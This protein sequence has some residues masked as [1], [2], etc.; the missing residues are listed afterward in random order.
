VGSGIA[1]NFCHPNSM[2]PGRCRPGGRGDRRLFTAV[3]PPSGCATNVLPGARGERA[4][5]GWGRQ[6]DGR[7]WRPTSGYSV[8]KCSFLPSLWGAPGPIVRRGGLIGDR[9]PR[10]ILP[11][12]FNG[13]GPRRP[14]G[15][16]DRKLFTAVSPPSHRRPTA[17]RSHAA[18]FYGP[19]RRQH[20]DLLGC[21]PWARDR[22]DD[23]RVHPA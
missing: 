18:I 2:A 17:V 11:P 23:R 22:H 10:R 3:P 16:G 21:G 6:A 12:A 9:A 19:S 15:Q 14:G 1:A 13:S 5:G 7:R 8:I 20:P 4:S